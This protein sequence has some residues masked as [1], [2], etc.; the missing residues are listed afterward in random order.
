MAVVSTLFVNE[1]FLYFDSAALVSTASTSSRDADWV[2]AALSSC[3]WALLDALPFEHAAK[4]NAIMRVMDA[5]R[6]VLVRL[7]IRITFFLT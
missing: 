7:V 6:T 3:C 4:M 1:T 5:T 2:A